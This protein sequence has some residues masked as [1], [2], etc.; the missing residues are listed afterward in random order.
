MEFSYF[1]VTCSDYSYGNWIGLL[2]VEQGSG[3]S[4]NNKII[5]SH[6]TQI[7]NTRSQG[8]QSSLLTTRTRNVIKKVKAQKESHWRDVQL[9]YFT[10]KTHI[11][12]LA[13]KALPTL[14]SFCGD[15]NS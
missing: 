9:L 15:E 8:T 12:R 6:S 3:N 13:M 7:E 10:H 1:L 14:T 2:V 11:A 4:C 5:E